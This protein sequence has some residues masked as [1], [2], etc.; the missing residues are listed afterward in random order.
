MSTEGWIGVMLDAVDS[1]D[2]NQEPQRENKRLA[3]FYFMLFIIFSHLFVLNMFVGVVVGCFIQEKEAL[4]LNHLLTSWQSDWCSVLIYLYKRKPLVVYSA[5]SSKIKD[6]C[7]AIASS[8]Y[9][10]S[11]I[12]TCILLNS[13]G[14]SVTWYNE[15]EYLSNIMDL[16]SNVFNIIYT[17]EVIIKL[18]AYG[19]GYFADGWNNFDF[20]I[21][22]VAWL[23]L[24]AVAAG[25]AAGAIATVVTIFRIMR[26]FKIVRKNKSLNVLFFTFVGAVPQLT[27]VGGLLFLFLFLYSVLG[28]S[29]FG[30]V[31][32]HGALTEHANFSQWST[33]FLTLIRMSTGESW[34]ELMYACARPKSIVHDCLEEQSVTSLVVDGPQGCGA[35]T[36]AYFYFISFTYLVSFIFLNLFIAIILESFVASQAEEGLQAGVETMSKFQEFWAKYDP[37]GSGF[38]P[39]RKLKK[40]VNLILDEEIRQVYTLKQDVKS[41]AVDVLEAETRIFMFNLHKNADL[42]P[43]AGLRK[44]R[45][46]K[47]MEEGRAASPIIDTNC[48]HSEHGESPGGQPE[49]HQHSSGSEVDSESDRDFCDHAHLPDQLRKPRVQRQMRRRLMNDFLSSLHIPVYICVKTEKR[50][51]LPRIQVPPVKEEEPETFY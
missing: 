9:F 50:A 18:I 36:M 32:Q 1:V 16:S 12:F 10:E 35:G 30:A 14:L 31:K 44:E 42:L 27:N 29:L 26:V 46:F 4:E 17:I 39:V 6:F 45:I 25:Q 40:L 51:I 13:V 5:S 37:S 2:S 8:W 19:R 24:I 22:V 15:P 28:V 41:G 47:E 33:A 3:V 23:G 20:T 11:F 43:L 21:V 7:Y 38:L 49:Q 34:H 48:E